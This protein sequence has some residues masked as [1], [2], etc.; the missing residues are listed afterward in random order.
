LSWRHLQAQQESTNGIK[1]VASVAPDHER[2]V[3]KMHG[4]VK[5]HNAY[6]S[7]WAMFNEVRKLIKGR[8]VGCGI[9]VGQLFTENL[10]DH[11]M[12]LWYT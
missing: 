6:I 2:E 8:N 7:S 3:T 4:I 11:G 12:N 9:M 5:L 10:G 1:V